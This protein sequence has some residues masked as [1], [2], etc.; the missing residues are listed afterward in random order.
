MSYPGPHQPSLLARALIP[1]GVV[2]LGAVA[3]AIY[4]F[5]LQSAGPKTLQGQLGPPTGAQATARTGVDIPAVS[6]SSASLSGSPAISGGEAAAIGTAIQAPTRHNV[7]AHKSNDDVLADIV[8]LGVQGLA[9]LVVREEFTRKF[10][11]SVYALSEG[12]V[13]NQNRPL[14]SP[15][16]N[17]QVTKTADS[18]EFR[19]SPQNSERYDNYVA[20][21]A[22][23]DS[24]AAIGVYERTYPMLQSA[25]EELG[26]GR[27]SFHQTAILAIDNLLASPD[28]PSEL[29]LMQP[30]V[31]YTFAD[32]ELEK[33]PATHKLML[34]IGAQHNQ[35]VKQHLR[36]LRQKLVALKL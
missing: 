25:F 14:L 28:V 27:R 6:S 15:E 36:G 11:T 31:K 29:L 34:R 20:V 21:L 10:A 9:N 18:A 2:I 23:L 1:L 22:A 32:P 33:L 3:A 12:R 8:N 5:Y 17:V 35:V 19:L 26:M 13:L 7:M 4:V 30:K 24:D 16:G